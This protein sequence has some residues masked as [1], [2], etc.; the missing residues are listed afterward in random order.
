MDLKF[1]VYGCLCAM[2]LFEVN[3]VPAD[4][5]DFGTQGD[6]DRENAEDYACG[7]MRFRRK[8]PLPE[9]LEKY[10]LTEDEYAEVAGKLE[11]GLS[12][13]RCGWCV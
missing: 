12:F 8:E 4:S 2:E 7:D 10:H 9:V 11:E 13:G 5:D 6:E 3:G 1:K